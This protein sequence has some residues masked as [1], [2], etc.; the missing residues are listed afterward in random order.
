MSKLATS[1]RQFVQLLGSVPMLPL[2]GLG[3]SLALPA[4]GGSGPT[5]LASA[6][7]TA[8]AAPSL[9]NPAAMATTSVGSALNVGYTDG[10]TRSYAF[11]FRTRE[12]PLAGPALVA[13]PGVPT[14]AE[15][16]DAFYT[17]AFAYPQDE[18]EDRRRRAR[19]AAAELNVEL[20]W[21]APA[22]EDDRA[23]QMA[24]VDTLILRKVDAIGLAPL[25]AVALRDKAAR[26]TEAGIPVAIFDSQIGRAHV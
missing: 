23:Q 17:V 14:E 20:L 13:G 6:S 19:E 7:F 18:A 5:G 3:G 2:A 21:S 12:A 16:A 26:A 15:P 25:D 24:M 11:E 10:S 8:M 22:K 9:A 4:C 1:R